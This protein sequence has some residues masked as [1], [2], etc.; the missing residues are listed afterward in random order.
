MWPEC[1]ALLSAVSWLEK[2]PLN[3][4][5]ESGMAGDHSINQTCFD[6][7]LIIFRYSPSFMAPTFVINLTLCVYLI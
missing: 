2:W 5:R 1:P 7:G 6:S 4:Y 3:T